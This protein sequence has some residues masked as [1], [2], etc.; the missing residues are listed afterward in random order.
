MACRLGK[1]RMRSVS[2]LPT[3]VAAWKEDGL[4]GCVWMLAGLRG[5]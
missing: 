2:V 3:V 1:D 4:E 5:P